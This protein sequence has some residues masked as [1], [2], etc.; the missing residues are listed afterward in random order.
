MVSLKQRLTQPEIM[1]VPGVYDALT[2]TLAE[3][4]GFEAVFISGSAVAYSQ[5]GRPDIGLVTMTEMAQ[6][7]DRVRDRVSVPLFVDADSGF[8]NA[9]HVGRTVR[10][11]ERAGASGIQIE[12]QVNTKP[13]ADVS[14]RPLVSTEVMVGKIKAALDARTSEET[15][16]SARSDAMFTEGI[17]AALDRAVIYA[18]AGADM[19]FIEGLAETSERQRLCD[20]LKGRALLLFN[21]LKPGAPGAP[22]PG[23]LQDSGYDIVLFPAA[24]IGSSANASWR[25]LNKLRGNDIAANPIAVTELIDADAQSKC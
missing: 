3:K 23:D 8:G 16:I 10:L 19:I 18:D 9:F 5:L 6:V 14:K 7:V 2:A 17:D 4:A 22:S 13:V 1:Q 20:A 24:V 12:D 21:L 11:F 25:S 15:I